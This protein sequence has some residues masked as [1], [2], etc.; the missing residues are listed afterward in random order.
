MTYVPLISIVDDDDSVRVA[1]GG[2]VET[3]G[4]DVE[5]F[6]SGEAF[7]GSQSLDKTQCVIADV[8]MNGMSGPQL[9]EHLIGSG[10][11]MP[12]IFMTAFPLGSTRDQ[13]MKR[14]AIAYLT[15]PIDRATLEKRLRCAL[16]HEG[17]TPR[18]L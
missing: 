1:T 7:L 14:G 4:Y 18:S 16:G 5:T 6:G 15:K 11:K 17:D 9:Q 13:V 12:V 2:L 10:I 8:Q 3:I